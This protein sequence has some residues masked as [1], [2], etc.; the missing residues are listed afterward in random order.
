MEKTNNL[1]HTCIHILCMSLFHMLNIL[2]NMPLSLKKFHNYRPLVIINNRARAMSQFRLIHPINFV[3]NK[4]KR[5]KTNTWPG[6]L[7]LLSFGLT[8]FVRLLNCIAIAI[9]III[10]IFLFRLSFVRVVHV[11]CVDIFDQNKYIDISGNRN[12]DQGH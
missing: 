8:R 6:M 10:I 3:N 1:H 7:L 2:H 9:I 4:C 5:R 12:S 11:Y